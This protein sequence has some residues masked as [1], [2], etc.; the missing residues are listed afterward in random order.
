MSDVQMV[1]RKDT[2]KPGM[3]SVQVAADNRRVE[4]DYHNE[5]IVTN[6][7]P[8]DFVF[9]GDSITHIWELNAYF[10]RKGR[11]ILNRG[12]GGDTPYYIKKRFEADVLQLKPRHAVFKAGI[13]ETW[14]LDSKDLGDSFSE[15]YNGIKLKI[16]DNIREIAQM[17]RCAGQKLILCSILP[18]FGQV[19]YYERTRNDLVIEVNNGIRKLCEEYSLIYVDYHSK[20][21]E[22]D[23]KTLRKELSDDGCHPHVMG[24]NI[25]AN[26]LQDT[27]IKNGIE[28]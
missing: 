6:E 25:M 28:I 14:T 8:V 20:M 15:V 4:F 27:I 16:I 10:G 9:I 1:N 11:L 26:V 21:V 5:V 12:I 19:T 24:Y 17:C 7:V 13:N 2:I 22:T 23:S 18:T 3:F